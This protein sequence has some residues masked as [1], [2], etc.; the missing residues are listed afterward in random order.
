MNIREDFIHFIWRVA[1]FDLRDLRTTTGETIA[2]RN[3]GI[4]NQDAGPD[5]SDAQIVID[6]IPWAGRVEMHLKS[7]DWYAHRH[8]HDPAYD[9]VILHVVLEEDQPVF[10]E[11]G[12]RIPCLE[13]RGRIPPGIVHSYWRLQHNADWIPCQNQLYTVPEITRNIFL[14]RVLVERMEQRTQRISRRLELT[15]RDWEEVFYQFLARSLGTRVNA[16]AFDM[17]ARSL[18]LRILL[19]HQH[20]LLQIEALFFGQSG[21]LPAEDETEEAYPLHLIREYKLL[22]HKYQL[23]P[24]PASTWRYMRLRPANFPTLRIA[25]L[26]VIVH[27]TGRLFDKTVAAA[28]VDELKNMFHVTLSNYWQ[29]HYRFGTESRRT[30]RALGSGTVDLIITNT[31]APLLFLYGKERGETDRSR[32]A[33]ELLENLPAEQNSIITKWNRLGMVADTAHRSQALL[34]L[35][36]DYCDKSRCTECAIGSAILQ[37]RHPEDDDLP[38]LTVNEEARVY[39]LFSKREAS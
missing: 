28:G 33:L 14:D 16:E 32:R 13:L 27:R 25:Q 17:L 3:F 11:D 18:P 31:I 9:N 26:A 37:T 10:R 4:H 21:L 30:A 2:I 22:A 39:S 20:S 8:Q 38:L 24:L 29:S 1:R 15:R 36:K 12:E 34:Q 5:F 23:R 7:S 6:E 35:K 19:K